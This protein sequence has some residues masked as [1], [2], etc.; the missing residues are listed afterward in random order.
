MCACTSGSN[1]GGLGQL[2]RWGLRSHGLV[3]AHRRPAAATKKRR[4][5]AEIKEKHG[6]KSVRGSGALTTSCRAS[7]PLGT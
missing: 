2:L 1:L 3:V 6:E 4:E 5:H 7:W